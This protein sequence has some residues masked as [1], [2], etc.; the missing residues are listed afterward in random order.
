MTLKDYIDELN[1]F[2]AENPELL[3]KEVITSRDDEGNGYN[4]VYYS[5]SKGNFDGHDFDSASDE[6]NA[7]CVN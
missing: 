1:K 2:A 7:V 5:P 6:V 3:D 4:Q